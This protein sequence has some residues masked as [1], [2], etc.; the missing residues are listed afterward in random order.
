MDWGP[1]RFNLGP[2]DPEPAR[3]ALEAAFGRFER[4]DAVRLRATAWLVTGTRS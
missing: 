4:A 1:A 2:A 3:A